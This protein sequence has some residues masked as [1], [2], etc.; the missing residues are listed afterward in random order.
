MLEMER[1]LKDDPKMRVFSSTS[2][3]NK[4]PS[5][6]WDMF[7]KPLNVKNVCNELIIDSRF[8]LDDT[9]D[10][11]KQQMSLPYHL[12]NT[13]MSTEDS[14]GEDRLSSIS[15]LD[16]S[17][18]RHSDSA[19][20]LSS[21]TVDDGLLSWESCL[22]DHHTT[23]IAAIVNTTIKHHKT[24]QKE[25]NSI[26]GNTTNNNS[27]PRTLRIKKE[28]KQICRRSSPKTTSLT[29]PSSPE[30][31]QV[32]VFG[33]RTQPSVENPTSVPL[34]IVTTTTTSSSNNENIDG[35]SSFEKVALDESGTVHVLA[36]ASSGSS[37][38]SA[39]SVCSL[40]S[41]SS[42]VSRGRFEVSNDNKAEKRRIHRCQY[43]GCK[44]G[45]FQNCVATSLHYKLPFSSLFD[46]LS[47]YS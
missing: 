45:E 1:Y 46:C 5:H 32:L 39:S 7:S 42:N 35:H 22:S 21:G 14:C 28:S 27:A 43:N 8:E 19:S 18:E 4:L 33:S 23:T 30:A 2:K 29:P 40:S 44:K 47:L 9:D 10:D 6:P 36:L 24:K 38:S 3:S 15:D 17:D 12:S 37:K 20:S 31:T 16:V 25:C 41:L 11:E 34:T 26:A 13:A